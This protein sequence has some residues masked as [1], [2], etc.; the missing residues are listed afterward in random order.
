[1]EC[2]TTSIRHVYN[3]ERTILLHLCIRCT[4]FANEGGTTSKRYSVGIKLLSHRCYQTRWIRCSHWCASFSPQHAAIL[5]CRTTKQPMGHCSPCTWS[6]LHMVWEI[7]TTNNNI[8][9][10][11]IKG[12]NWFLSVMSS[13][14]RDFNAVF[15]ARFCDERHMYRLN[16]THLTN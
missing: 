4:A 1:M 3:V 12:T 13:K 5:S 14:S 9:P 6:N 8:T 11:A 16:F 7:T 2:S 10:W 15:T